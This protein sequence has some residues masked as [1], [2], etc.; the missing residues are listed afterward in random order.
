MREFI[1]NK[2]KEYSQTVGW[3][4]EIDEITRVPLILQ[5]AFGQQVLDPNW[6]WKRFC[7]HH[8]LNLFM[9]I[10]VFFGT[11]ETLRSTNDAELVAEASYT[12]ILIVIF[13]IK[14]MLTIN[15]RYLFRE[16]YV[17]AK[18]TLLDA[19]KENPNAKT[20]LVRV[21]R[22][23]FSLFT[24][25]IIPALNLE[26][27]TL[28]N[29]LKGTRILLSRSTATL[30]PMTSPYFEIAWIIHTI[31][32]FEMASTI[33]LDMWFVLSIYILCAAS[34]SLIMNLK[35]EKSELTTV[36]YGKRLNEALRQFYISHVKQMR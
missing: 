29:Y 30:M 2:I 35:V 16:L 10:Y 4:T 17:T 3:E 21:R 27:V 8:S 28:W 6:T 5:R 26:L 36:L 25:V 18:T 23:V 20:I 32:L 12:L 11:L 34:D 31:F 24:M 14:V 7:F 33:I 19:I 15:N 22:I 9:F 13:P 1:K